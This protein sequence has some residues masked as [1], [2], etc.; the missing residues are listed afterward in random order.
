MITDYFDSGAARYPERTFLQSDTVRL[1]YQ[2][3]VAA[4]HAI[5]HGLTR[6]TV[7]AAAYRQQQLVRSGELH[8]FHDVGRAAATRDQ[9]GVAIEGAVPG[10]PRRVVTRAGAQEQIAAKAC[11]KILH[12]RPF[13]EDLLALAG[14]SLDIVD[15]PDFGCGKQLSKR[16]CGGW[17][18][19]EGRAHELTALEGDAHV[20]L[21][22]GVP[23]T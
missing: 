12:V 7:S 5:A 4:S 6:E 9:R 3:V 13:E 16:Q 22:E 17:Y 15:G 18:R 23:V 11:G 14:D 19:S 10:A 20:F 2:E 21:R 1:S 8:R